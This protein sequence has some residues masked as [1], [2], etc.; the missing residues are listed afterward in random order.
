VR[1]VHDNH[2]RQASHDHKASRAARPLNG[3]GGILCSDFPEWDG[4][5]A[6]NLGQFRLSPNFHRAYKDV[7]RT[8][9]IAVYIELFETYPMYQGV[10][11]AIIYD[12]AKTYC[13]AII[14]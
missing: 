4:E 9:C 14:P 6:S 13:Y 7:A 1:N 5:E 2:A 8:A 10:S 3:E 12:E 11:P